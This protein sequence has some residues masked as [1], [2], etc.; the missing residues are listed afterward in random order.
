MSQDA[1]LPEIEIFETLDSTN[2]EAGRRAASGRHGPVWLC[3]RMQSSGVGRS[4]RKWVSLKG[5][6]HA[7]L[8]MPFA[9]VPRHAALMSFVTCLAVA[10]TLD[11]FLVGSAKAKPS[12]RVKL[13]WPNDALL[14][15][16][17]VAG[18]LLETGG[19]ENNRWLAVGVGLNLLHKPEDAAWPSVAL[20]D[21]VNDAPTPEQALTVLA[22]KL[23]YWQ[24]RFEMSGFAPVRQAWLARAMRLGERIEALAGDK[25]Y[26]GIFKDIEDDGALCLVTENGE[27]RIAA[28]DI[29]FPAEGY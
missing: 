23:E 28:A 4:G 12:E 6:F 20:R 18:V 15:G 26:C 22:Q 2:A 9:G 5:N 3:A 27:R 17:K 10:E 8:L 25:V 21:V 19:V 1:L 16:K 14:D 29:H 7:T 24:S 11:Y 13:K